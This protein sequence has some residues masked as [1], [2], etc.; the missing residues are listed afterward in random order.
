LRQQQ[1]QQQ[2]QQSI[3][4]S[5]ITLDLGGSGF[6]P[7]QV[8]APQS[9][10]NNVIKMLPAPNLATSAPNVQQVQQQVSGGNNNFRPSQAAQD[11]YG[12]AQSNVVSLGN[13]INNNVVTAG[14]GATANSQPAQDSYG[15]PQ[16]G[17]ITGRGNGFSNNNN[18]VNSVVGGDRGSKGIQQGTLTNP[19]TN[20]PTTFSVAPTVS[21]GAQDSYAVGSNPVG[22][23]VIINREKDTNAGPAPPTGQATDVYGSPVA[24]VGTSAPVP[25]EYSRGAQ[26]QV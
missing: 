11:S 3:P 1:Q 24:P 6:N 17:V 15:V 22:N 13:N 5:I 23:P 12:V 7:S 19:F 4:G 20:S 18:A 16:G 26:D 14:N 8:M 10:S 25:D 9:I 2:Q 21:S